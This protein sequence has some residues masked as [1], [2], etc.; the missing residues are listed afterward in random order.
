M[1]LKLLFFSV[2]DTTLAAMDMSPGS[3][4]AL[5]SEN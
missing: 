4:K 1:L 2:L 5:A 3:F